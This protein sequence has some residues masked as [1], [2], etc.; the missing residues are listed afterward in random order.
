MTPERLL[1]D[2]VCLTIIGPFYHAT[3]LRSRKIVWRG[4]GR[5]SECL[6]RKDAVDYYRDYPASIRME[7]GYP[8]TFNVREPRR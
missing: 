2:Y 7:R 4:P 8:R 5:R 3:H 1:G 6:A